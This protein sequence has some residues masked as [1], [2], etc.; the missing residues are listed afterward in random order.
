MF[1]WM[2][3]KSRAALLPPSAASAAS[4][5]PVTVTRAA[6]VAAP[7]VANDRPIRPRAVGL[8]YDPNLIEVFL[9]THENLL[10]L[11]GQA[12][13]AAVA[14]NWVAVA[15][16]LT[17]FRTVLMDHLLAESVRLYVYLKQ[18]LKE[19]PDAQGLMRHFAVEMHGIGAVVIKYLESLSD[20]AVNPTQ[21]HDFIEQ[22]DQIGG[23]LTHRIQREE[24]TLYP[25]YQPVEVES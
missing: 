15:S 25:M 22:W 5:P 11:H 8:S 7:V 10:L 2:K 20:I 18:S 12:R 23:T 24:Q 21:R 14:G 6:P 3:D 4:A 19:E 13:T 1:N 17:K 9:D 16:A